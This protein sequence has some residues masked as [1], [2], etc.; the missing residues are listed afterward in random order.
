MSS[1][2]SLLISLLLSR[3]KVCRRTPWRIINAKSLRGVLIIVVVADPLFLS[4]KEDADPVTSDDNDDDVV[5][6]AGDD[7][8]RTDR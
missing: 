7:A 6:W 3:N 2:I 1:M 4:S 5:F 8:L